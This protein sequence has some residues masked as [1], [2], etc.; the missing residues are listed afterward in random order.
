MRWWLLLGCEVGA[1]LCMGE[2]GAL[3]KGEPTLEGAR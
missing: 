3:S 1:R 2:L